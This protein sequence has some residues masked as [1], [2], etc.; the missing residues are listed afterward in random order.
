[1]RTTTLTIRT[2]ESLRRRLEERARAQGKTVSAVAREILETALDERPLGMRTRH[3]KGRLQL[4]PERR[5]SWRE[6]LRERNWRS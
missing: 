5:G 1:M 3:L 4:D 2:D 6:A